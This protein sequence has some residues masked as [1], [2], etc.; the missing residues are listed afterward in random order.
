MWSTD[1]ELS[2][3]PAAIKKEIVVADIADVLKEKIALVEGR[4]VDT[5]YIEA[6]S[7]L[8]TVHL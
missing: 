1:V 8:Y 3:E 4:P 2:H 5:I 7:S 6:V